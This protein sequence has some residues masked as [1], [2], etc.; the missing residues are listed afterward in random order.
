MGGVTIHA[1]HPFATPEGERRPVRRLR[2]RLASPVTLWTA[3]SGSTA[4]GLPVT[5]IVVVDGEPGR[6]I[7]VLDEESDLYDA[8]T[9]AGRFTVQVLDPGRQ[10]VADEFAGVV[11]V[12]GGAFRNH[13]WVQT[14]WGPVLQGAPTWAGCRYDGSRPLG[15]G[16]LVEATIEYV[17]IGE[18]EPLVYHRGRYRTLS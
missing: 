18:S 2:G 7:G 15:W 10:R 3:G 6:L 1:G 14:D 4:A 8:L 11:P 13:G 17:E 5:S 16:Q 12:P 9:S